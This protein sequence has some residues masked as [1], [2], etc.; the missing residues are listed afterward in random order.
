MVSRDPPVLQPSKAKVG[1][2]CQCKATTAV[3]EM[4]D[5]VEW[6]CSCTAGASDR[7]RGCARKTLALESGAKAVVA[8]ASSVKNVEETIQ[9]G[10]ERAC[11]ME[12]LCTHT[13][14]RTHTIHTHSNQQDN[15]LVSRNI[16][17]SWSRTLRVSI[18]LSSDDHKHTQITCTCALM[19]VRDDDVIYWMT[20]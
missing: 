19:H 20:R 10:R 6:L 1:S 16:T 4:L 5:D 9:T 12:P 14:A 17:F 18:G 11:S 15:V 3:L 7:R 8:N 13:H 2:S